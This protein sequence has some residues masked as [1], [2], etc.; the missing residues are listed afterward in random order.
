MPKSGDTPPRWDLTNVYPALDSPSFQADFAKLVA[1]VGH[2]EGYLS[3]QAAIFRSDAD[4]NELAKIVGELTDRF[5]QVILQADTLE[6]YIHSFITTDSY[7]QTARRLLSKFEQVDVRLWKQRVRFQS[8]IG[9]VVASLPEIYKLEPTARAH[10][11]ALNEYAE[12]SQYLMSEAEESLA[13]D[14]SLSGS[15][16]WNKLQG[17]VTSQLSVDFELEGTVQKLPM[18]A[19]INL[20]SHPEESVRRRA[21][22]A[23]TRAWESVS[24]TLA[25]A[26]NGVKGTASTLDRRRGRK[27]DLHSAL[28]KARIDHQTLA[29][30]MV[31]MRASFPMFRKYFLAKAARLGNERLPWWDIFAPIGKSDT[32]YTFSEAQDFILE[33]FGRFS[34]DLAAL[35]RRAFDRNW[36]DAEQRSGK[37]GGAFCMAVPG[38][39]ESRIL[40]NFDG[41]L[42]T[43]FTIAHELGHAFHNDCL[44]RANKTPLQRVTPMT[45][46]ETASILCETIIFDAVMA[47]VTNPEEELAILESALT[48]DAQVIVD[49][50]SR[51]LFEKEVFAR[52]AKAELSVD[53][54]C[55]IM[56][57]AQKETYGDALEE[58]ALQKYMWTWKPHY[59]RAQLSFYNFPYAFG[60]LFGIGLYAIYQERGADF[61]SD[62]VNLLASTGEEA[63]ANLAARFGIDLRQ[64]EFWENSLK[65][66]EKRVNRY[67]EL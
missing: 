55:E 5:N 51:Y 15:N 53:E 8:Y 14:L 24:E 62:Y 32:R 64:G 10:A 48:G 52:R 6:A 26:L 65:V 61:V 67:L 34:P 37:R 50:Y 29:A 31:A 18:P 46:A 4:A 22:E 44:F 60:L 2:L 58:K 33:H 16:A 66:I 20:R 30:M 25:A 19:L 9:S 54:F 28:D 63:P 12:Q 21:Y 45:M 13:A 17:T 27:D 35:A 7:N 43:V 3:E 41:S 42:D 40:S 11:F 56:E 49:I 1:K 38:V 23:E 59:Y 39:K 47:Q 57:W 36:I